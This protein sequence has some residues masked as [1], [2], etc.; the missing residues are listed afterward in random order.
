MGIFESASL[1]VVVAAAFGFL[2]QRSLRLPPSVALTLSGGLLY[3]STANG[4]AGGGGTLFSLAT[5]GTGFTTLYNFYYGSGGS[6]PDADLVVVSNIVF[7]A[8]Q[9]DGADYAGTLFSLY[10]DG[11]GFTTLYTFTAPD[12]SMYTNIDGSSPAGLLLAGN[13]LYGTA[14]GAG[15]GGNGTVFSIGQL[16]VPAPVL[17]ITG[18][19]TNVVLSWSAAAAGFTLQSA[20]NLFPPVAWSP[21]T[22]SPVVI[23]GLNWV[24]NSGT[25]AAVFYRLSQ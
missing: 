4:G 10:A 3:G 25:G 6:I 23:N 13:V 2:N 9:N 7:G 18:V 15:T 21:V 16:T 14:A 17:N 1:V 22:P 5:N 19:D 12:P 11:T 20:T 24:T 8:T